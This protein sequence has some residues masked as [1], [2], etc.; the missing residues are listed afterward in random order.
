MFA[1]EYNLK[2]R[3]S[4]IALKYQEKEGVFEDLNKIKNFKRSINGDKYTFLRRN[5]VRKKHIEYYKT[6][7]KKL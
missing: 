1:M 5:D 6:I 7:D 3:L 4:K 2:S